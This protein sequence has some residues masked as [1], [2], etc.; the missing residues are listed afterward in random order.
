MK[1]LDPDLAGTN[2]MDPDAVPTEMVLVSVLTES[3]R[4]LVSSPLCNKFSRREDI[5][6]RKKQEEKYL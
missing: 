2:K 3:V 1:D 5:V 4:V 6:K